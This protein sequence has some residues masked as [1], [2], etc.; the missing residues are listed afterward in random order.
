MYRMMFSGA[1]WRRNL[2]YNP[3]RLNKN[4]IKNSWRSGP[5]CRIRSNI[6][7]RL[8]QTEPLLILFFA[9]CF[10]ISSAAVRVRIMAGRVKAIRPRAKVRSTICDHSTPLIDSNFS[11]SPWLSDAGRFSSR[12]NPL[13]SPKFRA[14]CQ[15]SVCRAAPR[16]AVF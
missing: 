1:C 9:A 6:P 16:R 11:Q 15:E 10:A 3:A 7:L 14:S 8:N 13:L 4:L 5:V 12:V 2:K